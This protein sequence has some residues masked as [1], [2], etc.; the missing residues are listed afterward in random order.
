[1]EL[2]KHLQR[3]AAAARAPDL[4]LLLLLYER[5]CFALGLDERAN[6]IGTGVLVGRLRL[7][8]HG[9]VL[10]KPRSAMAERNNRREFWGGS[11][12]PL[13]LDLGTG[14]VVFV[15]SADFRSAR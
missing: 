3:R 12:R 15:P 5:H 2:E 6:G 9:A 7:F 1:M 14:R 13:A 8:K 4:L 10:L 11:P